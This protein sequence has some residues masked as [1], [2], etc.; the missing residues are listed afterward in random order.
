MKH[1]CQQTIQTLEQ[2]RWIPKLLGYDFKIEYKPGKDN[3][4]ADALSKCFILQLSSS[5]CSLIDQI[6]ESQLQDPDC[7]AIII[8][9][10]SIG[11]NTKDFYWKNNL[12]WKHGKLFIPDDQQL[13]HILLVEF[14]STPMGGH[15]GTLRTYSRLAHQFFWKGM[16]KDVG[17]F[18]KACM[19]CQ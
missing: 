14:H 18:M 11:A 10:Q 12:L 8:Q 16:R 17:E 5:Q 7:K 15:S 2:Q 3:V 19:V 13:K 6:R 9:I 4:V 1:L